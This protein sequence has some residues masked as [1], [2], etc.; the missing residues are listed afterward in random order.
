MAFSRFSF[1][2][3]IYFSILSPLSS[4]LFDFDI[5]WSKFKT[6]VVYCQYAF[7]NYQSMIHI[8]TMINI[9]CADEI[10]IE[11]R[12]ARRYLSLWCLPVNCC[13]RS[14]RNEI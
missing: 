11:M 10:R 12:H 2:G 13:D 4:C 14:Y 7:H 6:F 8:K 5:I 1:C 9:V 3:I